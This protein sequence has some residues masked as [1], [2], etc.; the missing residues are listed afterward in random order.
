M[1]SS[2][3]LRPKSAL[4]PYQVYM[5]KKI[6]AW[7]TIYLA[8]EMGL[9]K[10]AAVLTAM[11]RLLIEFEIR[12]VLIVAPLYVAENTWPEE[13]TVWEHL[14]R[15]RYS[16]ITGTPKQRLKALL[17][18][19]PIHIINRENL[20]WL[21]KEMK[22]HG[23]KYDMLI[24]DEA[25]RLKEGK[26]RT[27]GGKKV[28][29][30][31]SEFGALAAIRHMFEYVVLLSGTPA[32]NGLK[33]LW[34]PFYILDLGERLGAKKQWFLNR[35]F[36]SDYMGW[37]H[38]PKPYA[39]KQIMERVSDI[40]IGLR[41]E[42]YITLPDLIE[43]NVTVR[44]SKM[45]AKE[46]KEFERELVSEAYDV[47]A[48]SSGVLANKL[49]QFANGSLY[50]NHEDGTREL[51]HVHDHKLQ[52]LES[53]V[54][55]A[56]GAPVLVAYQFEFDKERILKRY[57]KALTTDTPN[58]KKKWDTGLYRILLTHP[59]SVG[60]GLNLQYG[61]NISVWYGVTWSLEI[62]Q[63][64]NKRLHRSGQLESKVFLYHILTEGTADEDVLQVLKDKDATQDDITNVVRKRLVPTS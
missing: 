46:Y 37:E 51:V 52:A 39:K 54:E 63:Q 62:Y 34:G 64:F 19:A 30:R 57:P 47:E 48:A 56:S 55:E 14:K 29:R 10:T 6:K 9:G 12:K 35:W 24:Y 32:P 45:Q 18:P 50:R 49:L 21:H 7:K 11:R 61:G 2:P 27:Q 25:S 13:F 36:D 5:A 1:S 58:W 15:L 20:R 28:G 33:D 42:D 23:V 41:A 17:D 38:T 8:A 53:I 44:L 40:M 31:L 59:A 43:R 16:V 22:A 3:D 26:K 60:H 4:R